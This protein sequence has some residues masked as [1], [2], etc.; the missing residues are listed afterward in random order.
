VI[1]SFKQKFIFVAIPKTATHSIR[2]ALRPLLGKSD[3]EQCY[4]FE[5]MTFPVK[6]LA[7][8]EHGHI[9]CQ[10]VKPFLLPS[11]WN[12]FLKFCVV[13]NPYQRFL[14][15]CRFLHRDD[16]LMNSDPIGTMKRIFNEGAHRRGLF[17][18]QIEFIS[19][20]DGAVDVDMICR[21]ENLQSDFDSVMSRLG[22]PLSKLE[23]INSTQR[24]ENPA[25]FDSELVSGIQDYYRKDFEAFEYSDNPV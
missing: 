15:N 9:K 6:E 18:P 4:L 16:D 24:T 13:R 25:V 1:V 11:I 22:L 5:K 3:W 8:I 14:S 23:K 20:K 10:Q 19:G 12:E 7:E 17:M 21:F 2:Y